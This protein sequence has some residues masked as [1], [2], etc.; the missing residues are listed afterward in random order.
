VALHVF[1]PGPDGEH[2]YRQAFPNASAERLY[3]LVQSDWRYRMP[4][5]RLA[6]AKVT[7]GGR[8]HLYELTWPAPASGGALAIGQGQGKEI[9]MATG[10]GAAKIKPGQIIPAFSLTAA[11]GAGDA[12]Y[13]AR[14]KFEDRGAEMM[15]QAKRGEAEFIINRI[16]A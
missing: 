13:A 11:D 7:G 12:I 5:L 2:A 4:S 3:E 16:R 9:K 8:A 14:E 1:G 15:N 10:T 6:E